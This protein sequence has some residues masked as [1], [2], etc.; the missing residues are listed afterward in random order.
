MKRFV[1][2]EFYTEKYLVQKYQNRT[3][4]FLTCPQKYNYENNSVMRKTLYLDI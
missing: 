1:V 3:N 2:K 4:S